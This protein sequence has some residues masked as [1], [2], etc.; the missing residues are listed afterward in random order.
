MVSSRRHVHSFI[1]QMMEHFG[2]IVD[3]RSMVVMD[4]NTS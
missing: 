4:D 3:D 1:S 2:N